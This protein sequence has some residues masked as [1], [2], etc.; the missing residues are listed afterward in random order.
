MLKKLKLF[1]NKLLIWVRKLPMLGFSHFSISDRRALSKSSFTL[2]LIMAGSSI[3]AR[4]LLQIHAS[5]NVRD[6]DGPIIRSLR[7][8]GLFDMPTTENKPNY[9][10]CVVVGSQEV[11]EWVQWSRM[12]KNQAGGDKINFMFENPFSEDSQGMGSPEK[13]KDKFEKVTN[14]TIDLSASTYELKLR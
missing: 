13:L 4:P 5:T 6:S 11:L 8:D 7:E 10:D 9:M 3:G 14:L 2:L 12:F 1:D